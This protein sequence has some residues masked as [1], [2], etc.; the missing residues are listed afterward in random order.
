MTFSFKSWLKVVVGTSGLEIIIDH[1]TL[2]NSDAIG[3]MELLGTLTHGKIFQKFICEILC[4]VS[5]SI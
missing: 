4:L 2:T 5:L 3:P 1:W